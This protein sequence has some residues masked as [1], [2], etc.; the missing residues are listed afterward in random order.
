M[1]S[2]ARKLAFKLLCKIEAQRVF[3]DDALHS[4][5]MGQLEIRDRNLTTE[6]V[7]GTLRWQG[8]LDYVL[9]GA[10]A[11]PWQ[12]VVPGARMLLRMSVYQ[13]W[14]MDRIPDHA[15]VNDAV[16]LAK[17]ELGRGIDRYL[18][19]ILRHLARCRPWKETAFLSGAPPWV[20][21][22]VPV[23]LW[24]RWSARYGENAAKEFCLSLNERPQSAFRFDTD[25][26]AKP[27]LGS[28]RSDI[29]PGAAIRDP[30]QP[31][32][33]S[34]YHNRQ[35]EASQLIPYLLGADRGWRVW[36]ACAAP[37]GK[38]AVLLGICGESGQVIASDLRRERVERLTGL[39]RSAGK[40]KAHMLVADAA[41]PG[42]FRGLF[43]AVLADA[44]CSGLGTLR[45]N[46]EIKWHF[47]PADFVSL[48]QTQMQILESV[49]ASVRIGGR[50]LYSTCSTEP[51]ENEQVI[52]A[53]LRSHPDFV[54]RQ[55]DSPP[56]IAG[57]IGKDGMVR[58][59]PSSRLWD[60][61]FAALM[62]R[63]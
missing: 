11:R 31:D 5:S 4:E 60:G 6:I 41:K 43:D 53:F 23:W 46:P 42:P 55:P 58:T 49:S 13:M 61:F 22:S 57:W 28:V 37:G 2:P 8:L 44:P 20:R 24:E 40:L 21:A 36:D 38:T 63:R 30:G 29:V 45:R 10:S 32:Q 1:I 50:L 62:V 59:F 19:G 25:A 15:L 27:P 48:Q 17:H 14:Q 39:L 56:G 16:E 33:D 54:L 26:G 35:D 51:E 7:Y 34:S 47:T 52:E 3:S 18:N 9:S 12:E